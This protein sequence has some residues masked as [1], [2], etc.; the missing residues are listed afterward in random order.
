MIKIKEERI[1]NQIKQELNETMITPDLLAEFCNKYNYSFC[2]LKY[3]EDGLYIRAD[4]DECRLDFLG[5]MVS[6]K[7]IFEKYKT[8]DDNEELYKE[9][10]NLLNGI[11]NSEYDIIYV[12]TPDIKV[13]LN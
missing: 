13:A 8:A 2:V 3:S 10:N 9:I 5:E 1:Y 7:G 6:G 4:E 11:D 12:N